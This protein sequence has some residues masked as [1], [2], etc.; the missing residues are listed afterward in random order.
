MKPTNTTIGIIGLGNIGCLHAERFVTLG[1]DVA[2]MD[3]NDDARRRFAEDFAAPVFDDH[4][5]LFAVVDAVVIAVPNTYHDRY[6]IAALEAG[7]DVFLEKPMADTWANARRI[8]DV[9]A[10]ADGVCMIGFHNRYRPVVERFK[11]LQVAGRFGELTHVQA[12]Y[13]RQNGVPEHGGWFTR[14]DI[15]GGGALI[16]IGVH[17][18][19]LALYLL[20]FPRVEEVVGATRRSP[21]RSFDVEDAASAFVRCADGTTISLEVA[22]RTNGSDNRAFV[23]DGTDGSAELTPGDERL[24]LFDGGRRTAISVDRIDPYEQQAHAFLDAVE[25]DVDPK[26]NNVEE[27]LAVQRVID[28]IYQSSGLEHASDPLFSTAESGIAATPS[29]QELGSR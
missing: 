20:D 18:I 19:D 25:R 26:R 8:A 11:Q 10:T 27:A 12:N 21:D 7:L 14:G 9:A 4:H 24:E 23:I 15:S 6:A 13:V 22:W 28:D 3:S 17:A 29:R 2:G 5:E 1:A 16:D